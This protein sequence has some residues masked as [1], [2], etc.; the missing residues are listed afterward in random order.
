MATSGVLPT[1]GLVTV[2]A[3]VSPKRVDSK[4][5]KSVVPPRRCLQAL[6]DPGWWRR[7]VVDGASSARWWPAPIPHRRTNCSEV[8]FVL[9]GRA[10]VPVE[11]DAQS[12]SA[13]TSCS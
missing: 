9:E 8:Y 1:I 5:D 4:T 7:P 3:A 2:L 6:A 10:F 11:S 12:S 13:R